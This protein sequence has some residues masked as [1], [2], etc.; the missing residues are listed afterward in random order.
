MQSFQQYLQD[1]MVPGVSVPGCRAADVKDL[2]LWRA[3]CEL[4]EDFPLAP[5]CS[6]VSCVLLIDFLKN[7]CCGVVWVTVVEIGGEG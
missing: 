5:C 6:I 4:R 1:C 2:C 7:V 3:G